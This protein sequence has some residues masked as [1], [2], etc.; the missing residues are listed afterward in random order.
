MSKRRIEVGETY[1]TKLKKE[2]EASTSSA[3]ASSTGTVAQVTGGFVPSKQPPTMNPFTMKPYSARYQNLYKKRITLPVFEYQADFM[4][5]LSQHQCIVLVGETG[6]GKTTQIPQWC[7]EFAVSKGR[8]GVAC[9]QPRRVAAMSVAQR[10]SEEM[11]V[12]LGDEVG[13]SI[14]FEDCSSPKTLLKYMTDGMLLREAMS[15][16][17]LD[18]Y[19]VILLD[20]AHERTL[21]TDILM[22][23]LKEVIRQRND[24][25][26]VVMS[27][28]LDAGK[29][30]QYFDNAPLMNVP[31]RTHPVEIFY[32]PE[33]ERDYLEAAIRTVIQI[34]ICEE[35]EGDIL[36]F[37]TGQEEIEEACKRIKREIDNLG[38]E[39][40]ELKC[41]PLYSTLPPNQQQRIFEPP[42]PP[43]ASGAIGR[44]VVVSTNIA[45]TS[46][47]ID[48][49]VF[50][51]DPGFA[52]QKV[53][54]PRIRV[55]SLL[56]SP[57]SKASAQQRAGRAG[58][59]RPGKCFRLY[60]EK[61]FKNEMQD[62][63]Y[64][65]ILRSNL[66]TVVLQLKK[67]GIDDLVHFDF[68]DPPAPET[69]MRALEL[70]NY[71]AALDDDGNL[72]DLGAVMSEFPLDPQLAKMLIASCQHNCSNEILSITAMLSDC[73]ADKM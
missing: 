50:V 37:L 47:T 28:T 24:L 15:D 34:H 3:A 41:I 35:I 40:G 5:L 62:N 52:K 6:S 64:P 49:V 44:K 7:V 20:E 29:F 27:A 31:G 4:R 51:I 22:G 55:E 73:L 63:T 19:Q 71:L 25:K 14:R 42:P 17:M 67:L 68:M 11:D 32:T 59:T 60:T 70:L 56:V 1:T 39:I 23:V 48:G 53:Y 2:S 8:K 38:S 69:L 54:N 9:T 10:V 43:N 72:T 45:E 12:N 16:P 58:R 33:P 57:I 18:Q 65:E 36:M 46:L 61:A 30:Q 21:A 66:G 13:Y 26:L